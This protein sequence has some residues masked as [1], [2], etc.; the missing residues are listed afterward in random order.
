M[1]RKE[2]TIV[3]GKIFKRA[4]ISIRRHGGLTLAS[5][6]MMSTTILAIS[7]FVITAW[8]SNV[9]LQNLEAKAEITAFFSPDSKEDAVLS[10]KKALESNSRVLGIKYVSKDDA[11][12]SYQDQHQTEPTLLENITANIF[13][14]SLEIRAKDINDLPSIYEELKT[15][16]QIEDVVF[17]K[18]V[19]ETFQS[20]VKAIRIG[21]LS[22]IGFLG[23]VSM[24][25]IFLT[26]SISIHASASEIDIL[27]LIGATKGYVRSPF[28]VQGI[29]YGT[30]SALIAALILTIVLPLSIPKIAP[31]FQGI[32]FPS[33][34]YVTIGIAVAGEVFLGMVLGAL[35]SLLAVRRYLRY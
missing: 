28:I 32:D 15:Q 34:S 25:M 27:K 2:N 35:G 11:L 24:L 13:P 26:L 8:V 33:L 14:P 7:L 31:I 4:F 18:D 22:L 19:V 29:V 3:M 6:V 5:V 12:K 23:F 16:P 30:V 10:A 9:V 21:G 17:Y 1:K 20:W